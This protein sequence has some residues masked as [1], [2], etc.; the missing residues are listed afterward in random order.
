MVIHVTYKCDAKR[1][2]SIHVHYVTFYACVCI[3]VRYLSTADVKH[4]TSLHIMYYIVVHAG[5]KKCKR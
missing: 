1:Y 2:F 3:K 4:I 5:S